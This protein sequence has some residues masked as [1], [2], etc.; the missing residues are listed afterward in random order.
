MGF[1]LEEGHHF[2][3]STNSGN[4]G[5]MLQLIAHGIDYYALPLQGS[6]CGLL[7][8]FGLVLEEPKGMP[9]PRSH[10]HQM[11]LKG[12]QPIRVRPYRYQYFQKTKIEKIV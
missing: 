10:E 5:I 3:K 9:P 4:K 6:I 2:L 1:T 8:E 11:F 12:T 7:G